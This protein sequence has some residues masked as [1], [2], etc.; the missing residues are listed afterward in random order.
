MIASGL[1]I[2]YSYSRIHRA[3][4]NWKSRYVTPPMQRE[5]LS[6][7]RDP[8]GWGGM[9]LVALE[10]THRVKNVFALVSSLVSLSA[11]GRPEVQEFAQAVQARIRALARAH[12]CL[13]PCDPRGPRPAGRQ[14]AHGLLRTLTAPYEAEHSPQITIEGADAPIGMHSAGTIALI[15]HELATNAAKYGALSNETGTIRIVCAKVDRRYSI[16]WREEGGP[17]LMGEPKH[18]GFGTMITERLAAAELVNMQRSWR[19]EGLRVFLSMTIH[20]VQC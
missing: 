3:T 11:R 19:P 5:S 10:L 16:E 12:D 8:D 2:K 4:P 6:E 18:C 13:A 15:V 20:D 14:T 7:N 9:P 17:R 1:R